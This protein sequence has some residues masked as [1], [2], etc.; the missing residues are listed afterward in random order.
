M[1]IYSVTQ[2][3]L[4]QNPRVALLN[5]LV[6]DIPKHTQ[7]LIYFVFLEAKIAIATALEETIGLL[8]GYET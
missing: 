7:A 8:S 4:V 1:L 6:A 3:N 2:V 5:E